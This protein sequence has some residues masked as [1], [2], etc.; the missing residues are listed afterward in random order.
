[1][2]LFEEAY[3]PLSF[4]ALASFVFSRSAKIIKKHLSCGRRANSII[5]VIILFKFLVCVVPDP[6]HTFIYPAHRFLHK[7]LFVYLQR[8]ILLEIYK[9][10][11]KIVHTE[12]LIRWGSVGFVAMPASCAIALPPF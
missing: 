3:V 9:K 8:W 6:P 4:C 10:T 2:P 11:C 7:I 12:E 5:P 1:M